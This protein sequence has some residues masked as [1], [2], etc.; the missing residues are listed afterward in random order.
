[1]AYRVKISARAERDLMEIYEHIRAEESERAKNWYFGLGETILSLH[2]MP[3]RCP[4]A[5]E[6]RKL[7]QLLYGNKPNVYRLIFRIT[8]KSSHVDVLHIRHGARSQFRISDIK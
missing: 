2:N 7:R 4:T 1:M 6:N 5:P 8:R 3:G